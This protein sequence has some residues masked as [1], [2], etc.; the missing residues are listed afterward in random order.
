MESVWCSMAADVSNHTPSSCSTPHI[1]VLWDQTLIEGIA[2]YLS[3]RLDTNNDFLINQ[4]CLLV[5]AAAGRYYYIMTEK[6]RLYLNLSMINVGGS[7]ISEKTL[8]LNIVRK[9]LK[10]LGD[11]IGKSL[12]LPPKFTTE[13]MTLH[14]HS[15]QKDEGEPPEG[16]ILSD[17]YTKMIQG[18]RSKDYM[19]NSIEFLSQLYSG[20]VEASVT[21]RRGVEGG[22]EVYVNFAG[23]TT[24]YFITLTSEA[25]YLQGNGVRIIFVVDDEREYHQPSNEDMHSFWDY[26]ADREEKEL[27]K[28]AEELFEIRTRLPMKEGKTEPSQVV[29]DADA[30]GVL[31]RYIETVKRRSHDVYGRSKFDTRSGYLSRLGEFAMKKAALHAVARSYKQSGDIIVNIEDARFGVCEAQKAFRSFLR[32]QELEREYRL[33]GRV[34][35]PSNTSRDRDSVLLVLKVGGLHS[36]KDIQA[37][38]GIALRTVQRYLQKM[39]K[40]GVVTMK[41]TTRNALWEL[42]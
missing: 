37:V 12:L 41:G 26:K 23:V 34:E 30:Q 3:N 29:L 6:G 2:E 42:Q 40:E 9:I 15:M 32:M 14:L 21:V 27:E 33:V 25:F 35:A 31:F 19:A 24:Y 4:S 13:G 8:A 18:A 38:T 36:A 39:K 17:E 11:K 22:F 20:L 1:P 5:A 28:I 10:I 16:V 7:G